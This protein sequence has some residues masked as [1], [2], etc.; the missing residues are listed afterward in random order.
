MNPSSV[1]SPIQNK[2]D[3]HDI[4]ALLL[5]G[6]FAMMLVYLHYADEINDVISSYFPKM[7]TPAILAIS[8]AALVFAYGLG[9][10]LQIIGKIAEKVLW[11]FH[12]GDPYFWLL[13]FEEESSDSF[14]SQMVKIFRDK[15]FLPEASKNWLIRLLKAHCVSAKGAAYTLAGAEITHEILDS[16]FTRIKGIAY[17][18]AS[19]KESCVHMISKAHMYRGYCAILVIYVPCSFFHFFDCVMNSY[20]CCAVRSS[21]CVCA[22]V[23]ILSPFVGARFRH[24]T[25]KFNRYMYEGFLYALSESD[26]EKIV[27]IVQ[28]YENT[29]VTPVRPLS[30]Y[31]GSVGG[32]VVGSVTQP[33]S[34]SADNTPAY[35]STEVASAEAAEAAEDAE[36]A[37]S[38]RGDAPSADVPLPPDENS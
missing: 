16:Y 35:T 18:S 4:F 5:P 33:S 29:M 32:R 9:D 14:Q 30:S 28:Q 15:N 25:I 34:V 19:F 17:T 11:W 38:E 7:D 13:P 20:C 31:S 2:L 27:K 1:T 8:L 21:F 22:A 24:Y 26:P 36:A 6:M 10:L 23:A 3:H 37:E 12:G